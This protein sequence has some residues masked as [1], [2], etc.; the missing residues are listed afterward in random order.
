MSDEEIIELL[1]KYLPH[2]HSGKVRE[3]F[4][5]NDDCI[6]VYVTDRLSAYDFPLGFTFPYK[7]D[8]V[9]ASDVFWKLELEARGLPVDLLAYGS[10]I[11]EHLPKELRGH[12][13]LQER[14]TI[15]KKLIM[16]PIECIVR[17]VLDGSMWKSYRRGERVIY[18]YELPDGLKRGT[19]LPLHQR[20]TPTTKEKDDHDKPLSA[21]EI[22][23]NEPEVVELTLETVEMMDDILMEGGRAKVGD[24]KLEIGLDPATKQLVIADEIGTPDSSRI[25]EL[26]AYLNRL[27][28]TMPEN[29]DKEYARKIMEELGIERYDPKNQRDCEDVKRDLIATD[30]QIAEMSRRYLYAFEL[31]SGRTLQDF[32][33]DVMEIQHTD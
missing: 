15:R 2:T 26:Q 8:V 27:P 4:G 29:Q 5:L 24:T 16:K 31:M 10:L 20:F 3:T 18:G 21:E 23:S 11:D 17:F 25:Y 33:R 14:L 13:L 28:G 32:Q 30:E 19:E 1:K 7:G 22:R 6:A 9:N 12:P